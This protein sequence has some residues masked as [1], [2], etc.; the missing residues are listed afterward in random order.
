MDNNKSQGVNGTIQNKT[1]KGM[2]W[3]GLEMLGRQGAAFIIQIFLARL[4]LPEDFGL[5][6]MLTIFISLSNVLID[7]G[8]QT[9]LLH[10]KEPTEE[11]FST[12]FFFN[13]G[14]AILLYGLLFLSAPAVARF[15][16][17]PILAPMLRVLG[18][19]LIMNAFALVQR[20]QLT[21][22]LN[23]KVQTVITAYAICFSGGIAIFC[24]YLGLGVW[25]LVLQQ[26][27]N[28]TIASLL[29]VFVNRWVPLWKFQISSFKKM[30]GYSW[31]LVASTMLDTAYNNLN[32]ILIGRFFSAA[33]LGYFSNA[34]KMQD[35]I[36]RSLS[37]AVQK[38][39]FPVLSRYKEDQ[40]ILSDAFSRILKLVSLVAIPVSFGLS[41]TGTEIF[42]LVFGEKWLSAVP[43]FKI[44]ALTA[45][46]YPI[47]VLNLNLLQIVGRTDRF[48]ALELVKKAIGLVTTLITLF[49]FRSVMALVILDFFMNFIT[50]YINGFYTEEIIGYSLI[51]QMKDL[52][53]AF[54]S[55]GVMLVAISIVG[56]TLHQGPLILLLVKIVVGCCVYLGASCLFNREE[57]K[58]LM[59][60]AGW[61]MKQ[62]Q[63]KEKL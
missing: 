2:F 35:V 34:Q 43:Y 44:M 3:T 40:K 36:P 18:I 50:L 37:G 51:H 48:L 52:T 57:M 14:I 13:L 60:I 41:G 1:V 21:I 61:L 22:K 47:H 62:K 55:G 5:I 8:F 17:R 27:L 53:R 7:V 15:Y 46:C 16:G 54:F 39:S 9:W 42:Q 30:F 19:T 29:T 24:A 32:A 49:I 26:V 12:V 23:F 20:T 25:S 31:K 59:E 28:T 58:R 38:V 4:L 10:E 6:G 33:S 56:F 45:S 63:K 11:E